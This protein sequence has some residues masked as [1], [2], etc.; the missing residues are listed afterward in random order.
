MNDIDMDPRTASYMEA[1]RDLWQLHKSLRPLAPMVRFKQV[2]TALAT[3]IYGA[4]VTHEE[5]R[6]LSSIVADVEMQEEGD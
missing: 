3:L 2:L 4:H 1:A 5:L 6:A